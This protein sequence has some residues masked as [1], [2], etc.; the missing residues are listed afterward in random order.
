MKTAKT[1]ERAGVASAPVGNSLRNYTAKGG[2]TL[3]QV[4]ASHGA[5]VEEVAKIN[6]LP[7]DAKLERGRLIKVPSSTA[8]PAPQTRRRR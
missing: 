1:F 3:A 7:A 4:A 5:S 6:G 2:E 8:A